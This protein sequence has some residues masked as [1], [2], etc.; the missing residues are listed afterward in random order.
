MAEVIKLSVLY[1][2]IT[3]NL[4]NY[5]EPNNNIVCQSPNGYSYFAISGLTVSFFK[6]VEDSNAS[7]Y[8]DIYYHVVLCELDQNGINGLSYDDIIKLNPVFTF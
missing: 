2:T 3:T 5:H 6:V 4:D 7:M 8:D 1:D